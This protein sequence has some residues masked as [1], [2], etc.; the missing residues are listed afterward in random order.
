MQISDAPGKIVLPF[1]SSGSKNTIPV[2]STGTPG[3]A[4]FEDG[5]PDETM[6]PVTSGGVPPAGKDFNGIFFDES[7]ISRWVSAG[8]GFPWDSAFS[9][10]VG[11][12]PKGAQVLQASGLGYWLSIA[13]NNTTDPDTGGAGWVPQSGRAVASVYATNQQT[14]NTPAAK[15][16]FDTVEFDASG[17]WDAANQRFKALFT[18]KYRLSGSILFF[19]PAGQNLSAV[20][21]KNGGI[22]K[23]CSGFPQ[24]ST[25]LLS[26]PFDAI[27][28]LA[29]ND[30]LEVW[31]GSDESN[32]LIGLSSSNQPYVYA[33]LEYLGS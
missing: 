6:I 9:A 24:V 33:Q 29:I 14:C 15:V 7:S 17:L 18:G 22:A 28:N 11:G 2:N 8:A 16:L 27:I 1:G 20:V 13:D 5:F 32:V 23:Q 31:I 30:Y 25:G 10:A 12:Y 3:Q 4:S 21:Y 26:F 19:N